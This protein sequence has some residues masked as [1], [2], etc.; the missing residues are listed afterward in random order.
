M[1]QSRL[2][3]LLEAV[4]NVVA[5]FG[6]AVT[7]QLLLFPVYGLHP[8]IWQSLK[9]GVWFTLLSLLRSY[10]LRRLFE[11]QRGTPLP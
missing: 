11:R 7:L 3:S 10:A 9:I 4:V 8:T 2:M 5:G 1:T 6:L